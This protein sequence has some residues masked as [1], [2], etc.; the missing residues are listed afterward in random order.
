MDK[1][2]LFA[3]WEVIKKSELFKEIVKWAGEQQLVFHRR[4]ATDNDE[5]NWRKNQGRADA[6]TQIVERLLHPE[7][8][9]D[10]ETTAK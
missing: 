6:Y 4:C 1:I 5:V 8:F 10:N 9:L 3:D 2:R 7:K